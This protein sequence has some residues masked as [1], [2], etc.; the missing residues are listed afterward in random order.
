MRK[1]PGSNK[2]KEHSSYPHSLP[3]QMARHHIEKM[4]SSTHVAVCFFLQLLCFNV[5][6]CYPSTNI[7]QYDCCP[8]AW[9]PMIATSTGLVPPPD[10]ILMGERNGDKIYYAM[11]PLE[12]SSDPGYIDSSGIGIKTSVNDSEVAFR[13]ING[14]KEETYFY[15]EGCLRKVGE[16]VCYKKMNYEVVILSNPHGCTIGWWKRQSEGIMPA[17]SSKL[18]FPMVNRQ[19]F[20]RLIDGQTN[21][22]WGGVLDIAGKD[23]IKAGEPNEA[24][25]SSRSAGPE[26]LFINCLESI[27]QI[28]QAELFNMTY[29]DLDKLLGGSGTSV[30]ES[31]SLINNVNVSQSMEASM[32][33][34][35]SHSLQ[36]S[37]ERATSN[38][39]GSSGSES[40]SESSS[41]SV[42][43]MMKM[44]VSVGFSLFGASVST[45]LETSLETSLS[46]SSKSSKESSWESKVEN[47]AKT[48]R[49][50]IDSTRTSYSFNQMVAVPPR[51][52]T[53]VSIV[54]TPVKGTISF[55]AKYRIRH[56]AKNVM[57]WENTLA[58]LRRVGC[59][60]VDKMTQEEGDV[61][62]SERGSL[63]IETGYNTH[64]T[65]SSSSLDKNSNQ[66]DTIVKLYPFRK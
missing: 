26:V 27:K 49:M 32:T 51:S 60:D 23:F 66:Q 22:T 61:V 47:F 25:T 38:A 18:L 13:I 33:T 9:K 31:S 53:T 45:T 20:S 41:Y 21:N 62:L 55:I 8:L 35:V 50:S 65:I 3:L 40:S 43:A 42:S 34:E 5:V 57:P 48:G 44:S 12:S 6:T 7:G 17:D 10:A 36:V 37:S 30:L 2:E 29:D 63:S 28:Y 16:D 56:P 39:T 54:T 24:F 58:A 11:M 59:T 1:K 4:P 52:S 64:V 15:R 46:H 14:H 19:Y